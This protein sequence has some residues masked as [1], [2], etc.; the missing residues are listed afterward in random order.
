MHVGVWMF[1]IHERFKQWLLHT[2]QA[3]FQLQ[4]RRLYLHSVFDSVLAGAAAWVVH[5][6]C[7]GSGDVLLDV[8]HG[9]H[10][11]GFVNCNT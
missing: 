4:R 6:V 10:K 1:K 9:L 3:D 7:I 2:A 5:G 8:V 11:T